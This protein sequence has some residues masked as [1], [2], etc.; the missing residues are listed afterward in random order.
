MHEVALV[1]KAMK[2]AG[3]S[4][5][6]KEEAVM[7]VTYVRP[8]K[9]A[10]AAASVCAVPNL[11]EVEAHCQARVSGEADDD[12]T[13][14]HDGALVFHSYVISNN[15]MQTLSGTGSRGEQ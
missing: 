4:N 15:A 2:T 11:Q 9:F 5:D 8:V 10:T 1:M 7:K 13:M 14:H 12:A 3:G 6:G